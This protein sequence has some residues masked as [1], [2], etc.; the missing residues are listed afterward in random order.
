[1]NL[2]INSLLLDQQVAPQVEVQPV[3]LVRQPVAQEPVQVL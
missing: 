2:T 3:V 1:V